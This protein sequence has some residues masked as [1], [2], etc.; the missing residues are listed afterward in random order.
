MIKIEE[1]EEEVSVYDITVD[2]NHNFYANDI[3]VHNCT[4][5]MEVSTPDET[6]VCNLAS[7]ALPKFVEIP[8]GKVKSKDKELRTFDHD[9]LYDIAYQITVNLNQ[10][11]DINWYPTE[12]A[13]KSNF[14]HRPIGIGVQGLADTFAMLG[15]PFESDEAQK[16]NKEIFETIYFASMTASMD[17]AKI[18]GSYETFE[19]SP[20]SKGIFQFDMWEMEEGE[21]SGRWD[22]I[23]LKKAVIK[24]GVRNSLLLAPMPTASTAQILGNNE[25]FEPYTTNIYK[26][27]VLA[28]E[29]IIVNKH[30]ISDLIDLGLW[31]DKLRIDLIK[32][33]GSI[34]SIDRIPQNVKDI[35]RTVWEM[36]S[37][38]LLK[39]SRD[40]GLFI[41]QSQSMNL[42]MR[43]AN[44]AKLSKALM[45]GWKLGLKTGMY[46]LRSNSSVSA[47]QSLGAEVQQRVIEE[48]KQEVPET[49]LVAPI[50]SSIAE[51]EAL[52]GVTCSL[53]DPDCEACGS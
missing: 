36:K 29:Y 15:L 17:L 44:T 7:V 8:S 19:G 52:K 16:L 20:V 43:D 51:E 25:C 49:K 14:R 18:S 28:G 12:K 26:R 39:M 50:V 23:K 11:I 3:L 42:F 48:V 31:D 9:G 24:N 34:Q 22:W 30:L 13:K 2:G 32:S 33:N 1:L 38:T 45:Y 53:D 6:A 10:V 41:C 46:Y 27:N 40:R 21:L 4:E 37:S 5:I 47:K 35:Y